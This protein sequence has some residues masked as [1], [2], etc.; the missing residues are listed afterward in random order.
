[1]LV[2]KDGRP[3]EAHLTLGARGFSLVVGAGPRVAVTRPLWPAGHGAAC[4]LP[5]AEFPHRCSVRPGAWPRRTRGSPWGSAA[6]EEGQTP[7]GRCRPGPALRPPQALPCR[8]GVPGGVRA[9]RLPKRGRWLLYTDGIKQA[10][11]AHRLSTKYSFWGEKLFCPL[12]K[13]ADGRSL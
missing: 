3:W 11:A 13:V 9:A 12:P 4:G 2:K 7:Q 5:K 10:T 6:E 1:M 8:L